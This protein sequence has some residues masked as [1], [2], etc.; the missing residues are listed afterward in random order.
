MPSVIEIK[1]LSR[2]I[3]TYN[4]IEHLLKNKNNNKKKKTKANKPKRNLYITYTYIP[5]CIHTYLHTILIQQ[6]QQH[7]R[8]TINCCVVHTHTYIHT[9]IHT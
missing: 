3:H 9:Y 8:R 6:K 2:N 1:S 7:S 5:K 4:N